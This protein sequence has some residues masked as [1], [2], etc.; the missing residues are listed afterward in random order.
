MTKLDDVAEVSQTFRD[1]VKTSKG[2]GATMAFGGGNVA[3]YTSL[4]MITG[5]NNTVK[6]TAD[7]ISSLDA[8]LGYNNT[9][10]NVSNTKVIGS[11]NT[12]DDN[13]QSNTVFGDNYTIA[14]GKSNNVILG[15]ADEAWTLENAETTLL[16]HNT[17]VMADGGVALGSGSILNATESGLGQSGWDQST[18]AASTD[19]SYIWRPT[20]GAVSVGVSGTDT[21]R[22]TNVAAGINDTD[23]VNVAQLKKVAAGSGGNVDL[24]AGDGITLTKASDGSWTISTNFEHSGSD[25]VTYTDGSANRTHGR[26]ALVDETTS[27]STT[28]SGR[29]ASIET[30]LTAD[31]GNE[32][33]VG[34]DGK[35]GVKGDGTNISTSVVGGDVQVT[36]SKDITVD[37]VTT[38][39]VTADSVTTN[40]LSI[41]NGPTINNNGIDMNGTKITNVQNGDVIEGS[42][43]AVNGGQLWEVKQAV[44]GRVD[45]L[46]GR[47]NSLD[48][49]VN[50]VGAGAAAMASLHPLDF[51]PDDKWSFSA[52]YGNYRSANAFAVGTF[53]RPNENSMVNISGSFGSGENMI[54]VG[55]SFKFGNGTPVNK[56]QLQKTV[57]ELQATVANQQAMI[58]EQNKKIEKLEA[59]VTQLLAK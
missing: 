24:I 52:G 19:E 55:A 39:T 54:G 53:Y 32:T 42:K 47:I 12:I 13:A 2:G 49:K 51:D 22:I 4:T 41:T 40:S 7:A 50:R 56:R 43:D 37:S 59:M 20:L 23:A 25:K 14:S 27:D 28:T 46:N 15:N 6:G 34:D 44:N 29:A 26:M 17:K 21:R 16:G 57:V 33:S 38:K 30:I 10:T 3:D 36:L 31:D 18:G 58:D 1:A 48:T 35:I 11:N 5:V 9:L 45:S 8:V